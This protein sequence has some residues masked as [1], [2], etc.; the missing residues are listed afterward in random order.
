MS[1]NCAAEVTRS[2]E[3][4]PT[5]SRG[6]NSRT[7]RSSPGGFPCPRR[8]SHFIGWRLRNSAR[9]TPCMRGGAGGLP[10]GSFKPSIPPCSN[11]PMTPSAGRSTI[12]GIAGSKPRSSLTSW[13]RAPRGRAGQRSW[14]W[15]TPT[16]DRATGEG[17]RS[18]RGSER[19]RV[20]SCVHCTGEKFSWRP[21]AHTDS[22]TQFPPVVAI[23]T[24]GRVRTFRSS[25]FTS[26]S[27]NYGFPRAIRL[28]PGDS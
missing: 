7:S 11:L 14:P 16:G 4:R 27:A 5:W 19:K 24:V 15:P 1:L 20:A 21:V 8:K 22:Q 9:L 18:G 6:R 28:F 10:F 23:A 26:P 17:A 2:T 3:A 25:R 12:T 13:F